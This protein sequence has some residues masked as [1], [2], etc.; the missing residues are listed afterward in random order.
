MLRTARLLDQSR[1]CIRSEHYSLRTE[2][3]DAMEPYIARRRLCS[4]V[5]T[6]CSGS[7]AVCGQ[8]PQDVVG[9]Q[10]FREW[11]AKSLQKKREHVNAE[12]QSV[13]TNLLIPKDLTMSAWRF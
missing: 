10:A 3:S 5:L 13:V 12:S 2:L 8:R 1:W 11:W 7:F 4:C 6:D 9:S